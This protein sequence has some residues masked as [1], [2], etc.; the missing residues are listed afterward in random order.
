MRLRNDCRNA[1]ELLK[2]K[3]GTK[4]GDISRIRVQMR[5]NQGKMEKI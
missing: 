1:G 4:Q 5:D 3:E 2:Q